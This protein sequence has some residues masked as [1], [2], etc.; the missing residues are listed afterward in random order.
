M[1]DEVKCVWTDRP[2][3]VSGLSGAHVHHVRCANIH[4]L[5]LLSTRLCYRYRYRCSCVV[6]SIHG[7]GIYD[8]IRYP[9]QE[10]PPAFVAVWGPHRAVDAG[11]HSLKRD[12]YGYIPFK[13]R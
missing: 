4:I 9:F 1:L 13:S 12:P 3:Y 5:A 11:M 8:T 10:A 6:L 7:D 2:T